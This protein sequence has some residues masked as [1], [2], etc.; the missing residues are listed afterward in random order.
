MNLSIRQ[1]LFLG[2]GV[3]LVLFI[4]NSVYVSYETRKIHAIEERLL[5]NRV[6]SVLAGEKLLD[7]IDLSLA[8]LRGYM[9]LGADPAKAD[10]FIAERAAGWAKIDAMLVEYEQLS[11]LW[12][13]DANLERLESMKVLIEE[14]RQA[15]QEVE[16]IAHAPENTLSI[17]RMLNEATPQADLIATNIT[18]VID[19]E[20]QLRTTPKSK[21]LMQLMTD[22]HS[23]FVNAFGNIRAYLYSGDPQFKDDFGRQWATNSERLNQI[24]QNAFL[25][26]PAQTSAWQEYKTN[27]DTFAQLTTEIL[28]LRNQPDW[29]KA[30]YWLGTKAAPK[31]G[32][33]KDI[34]AE[35][36]DSQNQLMKIDKEL[37]YAE[38]VWLEVVSALMSAI[39]VIIGMAIAFFL[40]N[41][42]AGQLGAMSS[43][44]QGIANG[45]LSVPLLKTSRIKEFNALAM[46]LNTTKINLNS[47]VIKILSSTEGLNSQSNQ[48]EQAM[49]D[50]QKAICQ[51]QKDTDQIANAIKEMGGAVCNVAN[52]TNEAAESAGAADASAAKGHK[53]VLETVDNINQLAVAIDD[54][55]KTINELSEQTNEVDSI[56]VSI[57]G[58]ADQTNLLALNAAIEAARA[59]EQG[60]GF[61]V[62]ADEVR[63]LA[64][65]TQESTVE[66]RNMLERLKVGAKNAVEVMGT[67]HEQAQES[68][69]RANIAKDTLQEIAQTMNTINDM[70]TDIATAVEQQSAVTQNMESSVTVVGQGAQVI[71]EQSQKSME[72]AH[73]V[74]KLAKEV[75]EGVAVFTVEKAS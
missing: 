10:L 69:E 8:G 17:Q 68:V 5:E 67:G 3:I 73:Q 24:E 18:K 55:A 63:T 61:A 12:Q 29:N 72:T 35:L 74:A 41:N 16:N 22:S 56:L 19:E 9:I 27:R 59:G 34:L 37:L 62:V 48:L 45:D 26:N 23:S 42:L 54:A 11:Q 28:S 20:T 4:L 47:L 14:F 43:N 51:Q 50:S 32:M 38:E 39:S 15:Q 70:N 58:I 46:S 60:R 30:N 49:S 64:A 2:F 36:Y 71:V 6:P 31:A 53:V 75:A 33:I 65:S 21:E 44:A 52:S 7:G 66:I 25:L 13:S 1:S 40:S 57:S